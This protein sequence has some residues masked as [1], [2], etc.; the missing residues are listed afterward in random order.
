MAD[1]KQERRDPDHPT[2]MMQINVQIISVKG[3]R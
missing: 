1:R 2:K 3:S